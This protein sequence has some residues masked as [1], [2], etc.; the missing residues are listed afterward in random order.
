MEKVSFQKITKVFSPARQ[1]AFDAGT[2]GDHQ[3]T[4]LIGASDHIPVVF[5]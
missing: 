3:L 5:G 1:V 4:G 2:L